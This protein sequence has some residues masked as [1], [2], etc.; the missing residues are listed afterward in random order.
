MHVAVWPES[1]DDPE[2]SAEIVQL[3]VVIIKG[4]AL[5]GAAPFLH[6]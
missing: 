2:A 3:V 1:K 4:D 6:L 5:H